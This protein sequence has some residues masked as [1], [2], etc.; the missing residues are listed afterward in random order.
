[1]QISRRALLRAGASAGLLAAIAACSEG[2]V[3]SSASDKNGLP[4]SPSSPE[5]VGQ[6]PAPVVSRTKF[7]MVGDSI[8]KA[9]SEALT[10]V[11]E[12]QG[13]TDITIEAEVSRRIAV[14]DGKGEPLS[15]VKTLFTMISEGVA[16]DVWAIAMGTND[17][18][19]YKDRT[20]YA[21]LIDQMLAMPDATVPIIWVDVYNPNQIPGTKMFNKVLRERAA[22]RDN[23]TVQS[24]FDLAS[25]PNEKIL[26]T[27]HIHPNARGTVVFADLVSTAL[28]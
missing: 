10:T 24:W 23:T 4:P 1:M 15:G 2:G 13:F 26:R 7:A 6:L 9:S 8:T 3:H 28:A 20:E 17:V 5:G 19:K 18:G 25:A 21:S 12:G 22:K 14:G 16:P 27:D 11:L